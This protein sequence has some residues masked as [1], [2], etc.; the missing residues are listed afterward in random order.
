MSREIMNLKNYADR[1]QDILLLARAEEVEV[2]RVLLNAA[3]KKRGEL[4]E[5]MEK[6]PK[7]S[8]GDLEEDLVFLLGMIKGLNWVLGLPQRSR[9]YCDRQP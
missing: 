7:H 3:K 9:E 1:S 5:I 8:P 4:R 2:V 6:N